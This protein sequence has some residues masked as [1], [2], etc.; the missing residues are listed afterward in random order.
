MFVWKRTKPLCKVPS[1]GIGNKPIDGGNYLFTDEEKKEFLRREP[2]A[3]TSA[4]TRRRSSPARSR[5]RFPHRGDT[6]PENG[7]LTSGFVGADSPH[8]QTFDPEIRPL[9]RRPCG[10]IPD[11]VV[12]CFDFF[13]DK[14]TDFAVPARHGPPADRAAG[15]GMVIDARRRRPSSRRHAVSFQRRGSRRL[16]VHVNRTITSP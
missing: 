9:T 11:D 3:L 2:G 4:G 14:G 15:A 16:H 13:G 7:P 5:V 6:A 1:V 12:K 10:K 8:T